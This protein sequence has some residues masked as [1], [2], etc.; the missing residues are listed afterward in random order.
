MLRDLKSYNIM[1]IEFNH[2]IISICIFHKV[3]LHSLFYFNYVL[4]GYLVIIYK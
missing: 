1:S 2:V 3:F 4:Y